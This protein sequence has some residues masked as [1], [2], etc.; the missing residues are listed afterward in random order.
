MFRL[1]ARNVFA[2]A[3]K[4]RPQAKPFHNQFK[5]KPGLLATGIASVPLAYYLKNNVLCN[6]VDTQ[7]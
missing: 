1:F 5:V 7:D 3:S 6:Q 4:A 2:Y